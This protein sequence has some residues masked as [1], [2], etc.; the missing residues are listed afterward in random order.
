M[1]SLVVEVTSLV[2]LPTSGTDSTVLSMK[3]VK[4][5]V[6]G[7]GGGGLSIGLSE[8]GGPIGS[9]GSAVVPSRL[10]PEVP[11]FAGV[12]TEPDGVTVS[13]PMLLVPL[14]SKDPGSPR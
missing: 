14:R 9:V 11:P 6:G 8:T 3:S 10:A 12:L 13:D 5:D 2:R 7:I 4:P 1:A